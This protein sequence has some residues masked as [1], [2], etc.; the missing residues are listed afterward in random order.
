MRVDND[1]SVTKRKKQNK[2]KKALE[3]DDVGTIMWYL[4]Y[5]KIKQSP[6]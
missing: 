2:N 5:L 3:R 6:P 1:S 4:I